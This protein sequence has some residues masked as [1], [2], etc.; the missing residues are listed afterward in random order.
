MANAW[1]RTPSGRSSN[2]SVAP[3]SSARPSTTASPSPDAR[4]ARPVRPV[5]GTV[6]ALVAVIMWGA[7]SVLAKSADRVDGLTLAFH[8]LWVGALAMFVIYTLR[9]GRLRWRLLLAAVPAGIAF[10]ADIG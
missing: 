1:T 8:R 2:R 3:L 5:A 4:A 7:A 10:A 6:G 9:G